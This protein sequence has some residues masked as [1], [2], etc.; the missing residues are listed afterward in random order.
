MGNV[1]S[2]FCGMIVTMDYKEGMPVH[3]CV[4]YQDEKALMDLSGNV[5]EGHIPDKQ[6]ILADGWI[7]LHDEDLLA[8][9][10]LA[11]SGEKPFELA[12]LQ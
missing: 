2:L 3:V 10:T 11:K 1:I 7:A 5:L 8:N 6:K 12:P 9:W 4:H